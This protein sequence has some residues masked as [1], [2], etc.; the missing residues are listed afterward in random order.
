MRKQQITNNIEK[1]SNT[2]NTFIITILISLLLSVV[3][4]AETIESFKLKNVQVIDNKIHATVVYPSNCYTSWGNMEAVDG[5]NIK[6]NHL[7]SY[8]ADRICSQVTTEEDV[9]FNFA[10]NGNRVINIYDAHDGRLL[11]VFENWEN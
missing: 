4:K 5:D 6:I 11:G 3:A 8:N 1:T 10:F 2:L 9:E 7:A